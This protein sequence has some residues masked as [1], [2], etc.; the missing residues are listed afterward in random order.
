MPVIAPS[1]G[2]RG[3][4]R[5]AASDL[6]DAARPWAEKWAALV[7]AAQREG[8]VA[9]LTTAGRAYPVLA[10][11]FQRS[12]PGVSVRHVAEPT[13][14]SWLAAAGRGGDRGL[15]VGL[16]HAS[17][18]LTEG[19]SQGLWAELRPQLFHPGALDDAAWRGGVASRF[20]DADGTLTFAWEH[21]VIHAYAINT[22]LVRP[23]S[24]T[25]ATDLVH[26]MWRGRI[27]TMDPR[28][29][30]GLLSATSVA[31]TWGSDTVGRLLVDQRPVIASSGADVTASLARGDYPIALGVRPKA[32]NP[33][34]ERGL[35]HNV[36]YLDL[37]DA[38]FVATNLLF[39]FAGAPHPAAAALFSN[40]LLTREVQARLTADLRTNSA[41]LDVV[42]SEPDGVATAGRLYYEPDRESNFAHA[43]ATARF[44]TGLALER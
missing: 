40:W 14:G 19:R 13:I 4:G 37:P 33:L 23:G 11:S 28:I 44:V 2:R 32:L 22:A 12:F 41:R 26:P 9:L 18:A 30:T 43:A 35:G 34:R 29:G 1:G 27:L 8:D 7:A 31:R 21:Q 38:D 36:S 10:E 15:D 42:E 24:I 16:I 3:P 20:M 17:R 6:L 5:G 39:T 25:T